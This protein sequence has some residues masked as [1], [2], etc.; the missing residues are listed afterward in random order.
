[1]KRP[2][3]IM[4]GIALAAVATAG[5]LTAAAASSSTPT[6]AAS[7][8][9]ANSMSATVRTASAN[10]AGKTETILVTSRG[11]PLYIYRPDTATKSLVTGGLAQLWPPLISPAVAG[12]GV[13]GKVAVLK[14]VNGQQV[15]YNGHPLYTFV[16]DHAGQV[17]GQ[18]VQ[19]FFV[20]TPGIASITMAGS[21]APASS[22]VP[23]GGY[24]Y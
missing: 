17:T 15:T 18:G 24:G 9:S 8:A 21:T 3:I 23:S 20:A 11:L 14:D 2:R 4:A 10:V 16:D 5:G 13:T 12:A 1:M 22:A 19:N 6:A 7:A